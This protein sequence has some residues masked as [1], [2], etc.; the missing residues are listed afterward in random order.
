MDQRVA[1][2]LDLVRWAR[3]RYTRRG[4]LMLSM[5]GR[6]SPYSRIERAA[7]RRYLERS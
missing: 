2:Y 6:L 1:R 7:F 4:V 5:D 3:A